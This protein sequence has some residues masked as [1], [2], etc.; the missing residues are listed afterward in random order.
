MTADLPSNSSVTGTAE[1]LNQ[2]ISTALIRIFDLWW[3][4]RHG[5]EQTCGGCAKFRCRHL[6]LARYSGEHAA[7]VSLHGLRNGRV[8]KSR[9]SDALINPIGLHRDFL[10]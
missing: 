6:L 8:S 7:D 5:H 4:G 3:L 2:A 10:W 9:R 1:P